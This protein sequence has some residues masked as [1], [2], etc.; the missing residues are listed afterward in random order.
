MS[1]LIDRQAAI[2][3][4]EPILKSILQGNSFKAINVMDEIR[5]LPTA[6]PKTGRWIPQDWN[7]KNG[8][9]TTLVYCLPKC[10]VCGYSAIQTNYCPN[11]GAKMGG[12]DAK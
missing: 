7:E 6:E 3:A 10:S 2:D 4:I 12:G 11:C 1:D 8:T 9:S 5:G